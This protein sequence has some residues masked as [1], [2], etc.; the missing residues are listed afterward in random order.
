MKGKIIIIAKETI[1]GIKST[2]FIPPWCLYSKLKLGIDRS[3]KPTKNKTVGI[4]NND[5]NLVIAPMD[6]T[7]P[8]TM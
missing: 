6:I 5:N 4:G 3:I 8:T 7:T 2:I 1:K